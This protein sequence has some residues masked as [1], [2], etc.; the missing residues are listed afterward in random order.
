MQSQLKRWRNTIIRTKYAH[1][2][3]VAKPKDVLALVIPHIAFGVALDSRRRL[4]DRLLWVF[5]L[6]FSRLFFPICPRS[7]SRHSTQDLRNRGELIS[8]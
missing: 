5:W 3:V 1:H 6:P 2:K 7:K 4:R 8:P